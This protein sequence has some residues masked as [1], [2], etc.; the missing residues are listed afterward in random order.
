MGG[1]GGLEGVGEGGG[2]EARATFELI[3]DDL[4]VVPRAAQQG[5]G[6]ACCASRGTFEHFRGAL[7]E[8]D[9]ESVTLGRLGPWRTKYAGG[10]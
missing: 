4:S 9:G 7:E 10:H 3:G 5:L 2:G 6:V 1:G 8:S